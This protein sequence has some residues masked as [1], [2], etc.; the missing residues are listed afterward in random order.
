MQAVQE[1]LYDP[2]S[3]L[4]RSPASLSRLYILRNRPSDEFGK[5]DPFVRGQEPDSMMQASTDIKVELP[6]RL[7]FGRRYLRLP[8]GHMYPSS[9]SHLYNICCIATENFL[10]MLNLPTQTGQIRT[11]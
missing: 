2:L 4:H 5:G 8:L 3:L 6:H 1:S 9:F 11:R 10:K 7:F